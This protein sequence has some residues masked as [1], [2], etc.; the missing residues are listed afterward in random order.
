M[1]GTAGAMVSN[2]RPDDA[3]YNLK[4]SWEQ[5]QLLLTT[6]DAQRAR[7][8]VDLAQSRLKEMELLAR[9]GEPIPEE[10][11]LQVKAY[12]NQAISLAGNARGND[13]V[14]LLRRIS[15]LLSYERVL[16]S[17]YLDSLP[18]PERS[19]VELALRDLVESQQAVDST[20]QVKTDQ[21][22]PLPTPASRPASEM[23]PTSDPVEAAAAEAEPDEEAVFPAPNVLALRASRVVYA[24][25]SQ[26]EGGSGDRRG[27]RRAVGGP[28][29]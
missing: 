15:E 29:V 25:T 6:T 24:E 9:D 1:L 19:T 7:V 22:G 2:A 27:I 4:L 14:P 23:L 12:L 8:F 16:L 17:R 26:P 3:L 21:D 28:R 11:L 5:T 20:L 13:A 18:V 10:L